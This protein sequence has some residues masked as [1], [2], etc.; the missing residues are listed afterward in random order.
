MHGLPFQVIK[1]S[2]SWATPTYHC[3]R[4]L[5]NWVCWRDP[6]YPRPI[7]RVHCNSFRKKL[8]HSHLVELIGLVT[9]CF[10]SPLDWC[11]CSPGLYIKGQDWIC[12]F[13]CCCCYFPSL[14]YWI[15]TGHLQTH[16]INKCAKF[17]SI[18]LGVS[19]EDDDNIVS[20]RV[21]IKCWP[22]QEQDE[23]EMSEKKII[24]NIS[25]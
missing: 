3:F 10:V 2:H 18:L 13:C 6:Y 24:Y 1:S 8:L 9:L 7:L 19:R 17:G 4:C 20:H 16:N 22:S 14:L 15:R 21:S 25:R 11:L 12:C 23:I 5:W